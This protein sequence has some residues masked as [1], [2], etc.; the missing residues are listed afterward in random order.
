MESFDSRLFGLL[1]GVLTPTLCLSLLYKPLIPLLTISLAPP[2]PPPSK[3]WKEVRV[4]DLEAEPC[5]WSSACASTSL[6]TSRLELIEASEPLRD[7]VP[8]KGKSAVDG[9]GE[10]GSRLILLMYRPA[11]TSAC[12]GDIGVDGAIRDVPSAGLGR[13]RKTRSRLV[14]YSLPTAPEYYLY[15]QLV[16]NFTS[17]CSSQHWSLETPQ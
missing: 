5:I 14:A 15:F 13:Y 9:E 8:R 3:S 6:S 1:P 17:S 16:H 4:S 10:G 11:Y 12:P 7:R 2:R